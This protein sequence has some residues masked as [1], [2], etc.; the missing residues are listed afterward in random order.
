MAVPVSTYALLQS[1]V[2]TAARMT[3]SVY[4]LDVPKTL[5][6]FPRLVLSLSHKAFYSLKT[7]G[8]LSA[9]IT[10][11]TQAITTS[12]VFLKHTWNA[13]TSGPLHVLFLFLRMFF[14]MVHSLTSFGYLFRYHLL[15]QALP[16]ITFKT[17]ASSLTFLALRWTYYHPDWDFSET[18]YNNPETTDLNWDRSQTSL[19]NLFFSI[20]VT[21]FLT[22]YF[23]HWS[24]L[25]SAS[26]PPSH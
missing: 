18:T 1:S 20:V 15:S 8:P 14:W 21:T 23:T 13:P 9:I 3:L 10:F 4:L 12:L 16:D 24:C 7:S 19:P 11:P 22:T 6:G 26:S 17:A 25:S 5:H 2:N